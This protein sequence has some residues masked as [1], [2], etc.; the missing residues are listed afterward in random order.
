MKYKLSKLNPNRESDREFI[1]K[2]MVYRV[3]QCTPEQ[4][5]ALKKINALVME[6]RKALR[7]LY[8]GVASDAEFNAA[9]HTVEQ[10]DVTIQGLAAVA[11][12]PFAYLNPFAEGRGFIED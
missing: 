6:S 2:G 1:E 10:N 12:I 3:V 11:D 8:S 4:E 7:T 5:E 9:M